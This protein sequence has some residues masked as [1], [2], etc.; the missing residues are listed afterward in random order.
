[1]N[2]KSNSAEL[3]KV[4]TALN[5]FRDSGF[6]IED[7]V[8]E[9]CDNSIQ[10]S[11]T[12]FRVI[13]KTDQLGKKNSTKRAEYIAIADNGSG[14]PE[15]LLPSTLTLGF[16]TRLGD[17]S[18][19]GKYGV[20][21]KLATLNQGKRLTVYTKPRFLSATSHTDED[22]GKVTWTY[23][24]PNTA[25]EIFK[26]Y[27]DLEEI[28]AG[29]QESYESETV[30]EFPEEYRNLMRDQQ[31][32]VYESGTLFIIEKL[33][34]F[35]EKKSFAEDV[36]TKFNELN[37]FLARA[38][39]YY[40]DSGL[41]IYVGERQDISLRAYD[42]SFRLENNYW[43][44]IFGGRNEEERKKAADICARLGVDTSFKGKL[45]EVG[46]FN[47]DGHKVEWSVILTP[48]ITRLKKYM[49]GEHFYEKGDKYFIGKLKIPDNEGK[50]G[51][52]RQNREISYTGVPKLF[53]SGTL[54]IDRYIAVTVSFPAELDEYFQVKHIKRGAEPVDKLRN[55]IRESIQ[56]PIAAARKEIQELWLKTSEKDQTAPSA[57]G[58]FSGGR[59]AAIDEARDADK[60]LPKGSA[61]STVSPAEEL[62]ELKKIAEEK[63][64]TDPKEQAIFAEDARKSP[65]IAVERSWPGKGLIDIKHLTNTVVVYLNSNHP[66]IKKVYLPLKNAAAN[67]EL[68]ASMR[69]ALSNAADGIDLLFFAYAKA[70][71]QSMDPDEDFGMLREDWGKFASSYLKKMAEVDVR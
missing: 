56:K 13:M 48:E 11:A 30:E 38:F 69:T 16:G 1:M 20:G 41:K 29:T 52:L 35:N 18:G 27:L 57:G 53:P 54:D 64:I 58:D 37:Y 5:S 21:F 55:K 61:G 22:T 6:S 4:D 8:G 23:A 43:D 9:Y 39:R 46:E 17:R 12:E 45:G 2:T 10:A 32:N 26:T 36:E 42:P 67:S 71:N 40:I 33:D 50:V 65:I 15:T 59:K 63:G 7:A 51:F 28:M 60:T 25:G 44:W 70:E 34:R 68:P 31:G 24:D 66:F 3:I 14:I 49:A 62:N 47:I 19:I